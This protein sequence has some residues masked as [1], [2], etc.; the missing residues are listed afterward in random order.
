MEEEIKKDNLHVPRP[1]SG[2][3]CDEQHVLRI[4]EGLRANC[5]ILL[6]ATIEVMEKINPDFD[7]DRARK[8]KEDVFEK[9]GI[10]EEE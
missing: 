1:I 8:I 10:S 5:I 6:K 2:L 4:S 7:S 3:S 9:Y